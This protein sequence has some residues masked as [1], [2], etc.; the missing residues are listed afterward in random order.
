[1]GTGAKGP[2]PSI[3]FQ[4]ERLLGRAEGLIPQP[5]DARSDGQFP[6]RVR[7]HFEGGAAHPA[8]LCPQDQD[9]SCCRGRAR[10]PCRW[11][12]G[13]V[14]NLIALSAC[15]HLPR[16]S[17]AA[18]GSPPA[19]S[20]PGKDPAHWGSWGWWA[21]GRCTAD[22]PRRSSAVTT[23][24]SRRNDNDDAHQET[25]FQPNSHS[26]APTS[27]LPHDKGRSWVSRGWQ[28]RARAAA[29]AGAAPPAAPWDPPGCHQPPAGAAVSLGGQAG[30]LSP[31]VPAAAL[32]LMT[33]SARLAP[34][35]T[36]P[37]R[38]VR[39][40]S[41]RSATAA[42]PAFFPRSPCRSLRSPW[43]P[44]SLEG[45]RGTGCRA[46]GCP[47]AGRQRGHVAHIEPPACLLASV[48]EGSR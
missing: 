42:G 11:G 23:L 13:C 28:L 33:S 47:G 30:S 27:V 21:K 14:V 34:Q 18:A 4:S 7:R 35:L 29:C 25:L 43:A 31:R 10:R 20:W 12:G 15:C 22:V 40:H 44:G 41:Q 17:P 19:S 39:L 6:G 2:C 16:A 9:G 32:P 38:L 8:P 5:H 3:R 37:R 46:H 48:R 26:R 24:L 36:P 45:A 1:M